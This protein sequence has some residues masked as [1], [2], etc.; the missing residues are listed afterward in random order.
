MP[1]MNLWA[2]LGGAARN[3]C[4]TLC[5]DDRILGICE[6]E[7]ITRV[8]AAGF[9]PTGLPDEALDELLRRSGRRRSDVTGYAVAETIPAPPPMELTCLDH[10][11]THACSA[12]LPSPF[13]CATIVVCDHES[14][15]MS[16][17]DG[18]GTAVTRIEWPWDGPGFADV[19]SGCAEALG[20]T[21]EGREQRMEALARLDP[22]RRDNRAQ[23]LFHLDGDRLRLATGWQAC[24][25]SWT[26]AS[27]PLEEACGLAAALQSRI[28]DLLLEFLAE[29]RS[30]TPASRRL[31]VGGSLFH[32]SHFNGR[33]KRSAVFDEVFVPINPGNAGLA[34]GAALHVSEHVRGPVTPFL[35][36]SYSPD[37]IKATLD[38]CK[39]SYDWVSTG[40][41]ITIAL[42]ALKKGRMV[43]WFDGPMEWGPRALGARSILANPF[44]PFVLDNLNQFLKQREVWRGYA[45]SGLD[46]AVREHFEGPED[47]SFM[48]CD[49][50]PRDRQRFKHVLPES[51]AHVRV[52]TVGPAAPPRFRALLHA[53][54]EAAGI[55]IVVNTSFNGFSE[56][57]VCNPRDAVRV[58]FGTGIDTLIL[59]Q[60]VIRK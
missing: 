28:G 6:Q 48:E 2:G 58:F 30:R 16:V 12:F 11:F 54:G 40:D 38:N 25:S 1:S 55:P 50:A 60:F 23:Q 43:A 4:V 14:P 24:I 31:C 10:H 47:S 21:S 34:V 29:V 49:Y 45:L 9:N 19:Y 27:A 5:T 37:E 8:R 53:F 13:D 51:N 26:G 42:D 20:F 35:G 36:P 33:L 57:I 32:N 18:N 46:A 59:D 52:Q 15:R 7:R 41:T 22:D 44:A 56:P 17:W 3:A 39:L